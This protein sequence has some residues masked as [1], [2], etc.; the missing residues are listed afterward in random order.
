MAAAYFNAEQLAVLY[1]ELDHE[2]AEYARAHGHVTAVQRNLIA[3]RIMEAAKNNPPSKT[4]LTA[5]P[6]GMQFT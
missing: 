4:S 3:A 1:R 6:H 5:G 2:C